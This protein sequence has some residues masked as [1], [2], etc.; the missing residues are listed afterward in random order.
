MTYWADR[1]FSVPGVMGW[2]FYDKQPARVRGL[3]SAG[4]TPC[5]F[6]QAQVSVPEENMV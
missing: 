3:P 6:K 4:R 5:M 1:E 2:P